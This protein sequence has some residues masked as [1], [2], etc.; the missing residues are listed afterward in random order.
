MTARAARRTST[1]PYETWRQAY[2][3]VAALHARCRFGQPGAMAAE[4]ADL[5]REACQR[6][7]VTVGSF[8]ADVLRWLAGF[9]PENCAVIAGLIARAHAAGRAGRNRR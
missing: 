3:D 2:G 1:G 9:E 7:D 6:A 8:D 5:L 4:N